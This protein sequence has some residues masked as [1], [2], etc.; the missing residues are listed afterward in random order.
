MALSR[1]DGHQDSYSLANDAS[2]DYG[3]DFSP[4]Q[5]EIINQLLTQIP[6]VGRPSSPS[7]L[8]RDIEDHEVPDLARVPRTIFR[9]RKVLLQDLDNQNTQALPTRIKHKTQELVGGVAS[10]MSPLVTIAS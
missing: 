4:E 8:V 2:S 1:D 5:D 9:R 7:H 10:G 3:S 6:Q